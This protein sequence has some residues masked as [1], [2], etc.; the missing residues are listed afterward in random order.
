M[1]EETKKAKNRNE[2]RLIVSFYGDYIYR[3]YF[4]HC[5]EKFTSVLKEGKASNLSMQMICQAIQ[6][7][8]FWRRKNLPLTPFKI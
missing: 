1:E 8:N 7:R 3:V 5:S 6:T 4:Y 2:I